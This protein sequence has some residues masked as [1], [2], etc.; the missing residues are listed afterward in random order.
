MA[1]KL[2]GLGKGLNAIFM[3][4]DAED[5]NSTV[6][7]RLSDI[8]PNKDQPRKEFDDTAL[9]DLAESISK[10]GLLQ[11]IL[12]RPIIGGGYQIVAGERRYRASRM[13]GLTEVPVIIRELSESETMEIA[14]IENLQRENLTPI[15]EA[16]GYRTLMEEHDFSQDEVSKAVG[17]SRSAVANALRLLKLPEDILNM[18]SAGVISAGHAR[19]L[20]KIDDSDLRKEALSKMISEHLN[21]SQA[22]EMINSMLTQNS[23]IT[24]KTGKQMIVVKD[25]RIFLNTINKAV[26][27][28]RMAGI[29]AISKKHDNGDYIEYTI[30]IPKQQSKNKT[31]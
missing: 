12:V 19:A 10:H 11:P 2:G 7:L 22:E 14:L 16:L 28:M 13:A 8:E 6:T 26:D 15:E 4:N 29:D 31:A 3:E 18:V 5:N 21:V 27:T 23:I 25:I 30:K 20:L 17:K 1:K 9:A 24:K